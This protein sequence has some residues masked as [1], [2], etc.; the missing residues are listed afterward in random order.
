MQ[1]P[2]LSKKSIAR[3]AMQLTEDFEK[4]AGYRIEPPIPVDE[5]IERSLG[6]NLCYMDLEKTLG[7]GV[8][9][10]TYAKA[11][12]V[13]INERLFENGSEGR[14]VFTCA[15]E[16]GHWVLHL[17]YAELQERHARRG[18]AIVCRIKDAREPI[19]WQADYFAS[20]L[21]MPERAVRQAF[22]RLCGPAP[23]VIK[24]S[25]GSEGAADDSGEPYL[26]QWPVIA[27]ALCEA[28]GFSN[29]S[30]QAMIIRLQDL[31]LLINKTGAAMDWQALLGD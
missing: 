24:N 16:A 5:I 6:L 20:C 13:C 2:W 30:K 7:R 28:G 18:E 21:L 29:V 12:L 11:R 26:E 19:E 8:L 17:P 23:I 15:H 10:A 3:K 14:L 4:Q 25:L 31:G 9:G 1:V 22:E 27:A